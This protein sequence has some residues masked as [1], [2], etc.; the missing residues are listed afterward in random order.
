M[1]KAF[2]FP[3]D[4]NFVFSLVKTWHMTAI[5]ISMSDRWKFISVKYGWCMIWIDF[6]PYYFDHQS[7]MCPKNCGPQENKHHLWDW[8]IYFHRQSVT[9][10][11][12]VLFSWGPHFDGHI[13]W[14]CK[15]D[16]PVINFHLSDIEI[17]TAVTCHVLT[18]ENTTF[19][20][21]GK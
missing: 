15:G 10:L 21:E 13:L 19:Q 9:N 16:S 3:T 17:Y 14:R 12:S 1:F 4:L 20:S 18:C 11:I 8:S 6:I 7:C 5:Y 2:Y